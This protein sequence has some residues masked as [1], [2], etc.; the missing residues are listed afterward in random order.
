MSLGRCRRHPSSLFRKSSRLPKDKKG[1]NHNFSVFW[2]CPCLRGTTCVHSFRSSFTLCHIFSDDIN[3]FYLGDN[4]VEAH[5][6][7]VLQRLHDVGFLQEGFNS[8]GAWLQGLHCYF[9][10]VVVVSW[11]CR[12]RKREVRGFN[13]AALKRDFFSLLPPAIKQCSF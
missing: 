13:T 3:G 6:P 8:H 9:S 10:W 11:W 5:Q 2:L 4:G 1:R 12:W 7:E